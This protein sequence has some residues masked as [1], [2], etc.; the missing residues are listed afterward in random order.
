MSLHTQSLEE[1]GE[2]KVSTYGSSE[3]RGLAYALMYGLL[4]IARAIEAHR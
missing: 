4:A 1:I 2:R 3:Y